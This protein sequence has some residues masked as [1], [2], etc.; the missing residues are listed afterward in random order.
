MGL[1]PDAFGVQEGDAKTPVPV[2]EIRSFESTGQGVAYMI[3][4]DNSLSM[5]GWFD[6]VREALRAFLRDRLRD[7]DRVSIMTVN[8]DATLA[9]E[10]NAT[11]IAVADAVNSLA[12]AGKKTELYLGVNKGFD[13][14]SMAD[15]P[16]RRVMLVISDGKDEGKDYTLDS[17]IALARERGVAIYSLGVTPK[18]GEALLNMQRLS[19]ETGGSY[20]LAGDK[21]E[22][23]GKLDLLAEAVLERYILSYTSAL[24]RDGKTHPVIVTAQVGDAPV[25]EELLIETPAPPPKEPP[26][27]PPE[28]GTDWLLIGI[29]AAAVV[30][31]VIVVVVFMVSS[32]KSG[33]KIG[34][35]EQQRREEAAR[36][37][38]ELGEKL[39]SVKRDVEGIH[40]KV[41]K[42][43]PAPPPPPP[44]R[45][46]MVEGVASAPSSYSSAS[47]YVE[48][49]P[50]QGSNLPLLNTKTTIGRENDNNVVLPHDKVS[51]NHAE[52]VCEGGV[53]YL[54]DLGST[55]GTFVD[56]ARITERVS[57]H[58][59]NR[60]RMGGATLVFKG[61]A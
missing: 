45:R 27:P 50:M 40:G 4:L 11:A 16:E 37:E 19:K 26:P 32:S 42:P 34:Q 23:A 5:R 13:S 35:L 48:E 59:G 51:A 6:E 31:L 1:G 38:A 29:V 41:A 25:R 17:T 12:P 24:P 18:G 3:V 14:L 21:A 55:N 28:K 36:M 53:Y 52:V 57:L 22:L 56:G 15:I 61:E 8:D 39:D 49:G 20:V 47:L 44:K 30:L 54:A 2:E 58:A 7:R 10:F 33:K 60:I 46:T 43:A 9:A